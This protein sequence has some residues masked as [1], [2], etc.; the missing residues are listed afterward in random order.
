MILHSEPPRY[1]TQ[2]AQVTPIDATSFSAGGVY[3][4]QIPVSSSLNFPY[5]SEISISALANSCYSG[6]KPAAVIALIVEAD[7]LDERG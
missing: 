6:T 4:A 5:L 1:K 3:P 7:F 2:L